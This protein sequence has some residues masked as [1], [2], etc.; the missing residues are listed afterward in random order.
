MAGMTR[1]YMPDLLSQIEKEKKLYE[2]QYMPD[3]LGQFEAER[4]ALED[5]TQAEIDPYAMVGDV[6]QKAQPREGAEK[7][8]DPKANRIKLLKDDFRQKFGYEM[9]DN[10]VDQAIKTGRYDNPKHPSNIQKRLDREYQE[11]LEKFGMTEKDLD[12]QLDRIATEPSDDKSDNQQGAEKK[13]PPV[14][15]DPLDKSKVIQ[16][17]STVDTPRTATTSGDSVYDLMREIAGTKEEAKKE[18]FANAMIQLGAGVASGNLAAGLSAAGKAASETMGNY[19]DRALKGRLAEVQ[20]K[21]A[22]EQAAYRRR[23]EELS[24]RR[25]DR[26]S[27]TQA[28]AALA[29]RLDEAN[30]MINIPALLAEKLGRDPTDKEIRDETDRQRNR[31]IDAVATQYGVERGLLGG[32]PSDI[33][34]EEDSPAT[35]YQTDPSAPKLVD[36]N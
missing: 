21:R 12:A 33:E 20:L 14:I 28:N 13:P 10:L 34:E 6:I 1:P 8:V 3:P 2:K 29:K 25:E 4:A 11:N 15:Y 36:V 7:L 26:Y 9:P 24:T 30:F 32:T 5:V 35:Q 17:G 19:R 16:Q 27:V 31:I 22:D 18:A 23:Q